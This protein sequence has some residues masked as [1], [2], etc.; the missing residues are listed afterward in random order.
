MDQRPAEPRS[1]KFFFYALFVLLFAPIVLL[2]YVLLSQNFDSWHLFIE[3]YTALGI[4]YMWMIFLMLYLEERNARSNTSG[5]T[6]YRGDLISVLVPCYNEHRGL[7]NRAIKSVYFADGNKE[8][9]IVDDGSTNDLDEILLKLSRKEGIK[10]RRFPSNK[11]KRHA[12]HEAVKNISPESKFVVTI[13]SDT[14]VGK[15]TLVRLVAPLYDQNIGAVSGNVEL[16]NEKDNWLTRA[17]AA[18]YWSALSIQ[19]RSQ[20]SI[21][22]V[23]CCSGCCAAYRSDIVRD[24]IDDFVSHTF[25]GIRT[26]YSEDRHLTNLVLKQGLKVVFATNAVVYTYSPST[27]R[28]FMKQQIRWRRGFIQ[29]STY[30]LTFT[31]KTQPLLFVQLLFWDL[32]LPFVSFAA[33]VMSLILVVLQPSTIFLIIPAMLIYMVIRNLPMVIHAKDKII[34]MILFSFLF[35]TILYWQSAYALFTVKNNR[36][37][38]RERT[39]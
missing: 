12:L 19:R 27:L 14:L 26:K 18:Y 8:I 2:A 15:D 9:I 29:E 17:I 36:W 20:S 23:S 21:G 7:L 13:D 28:A 31:W 34:G 3:I 5:Q 38:T 22:I 11:G 30:A 25:F 16:L 1:Q 10:V 35:E 6:E 24:V 37:A 33:V 39:T 32:T 4:S